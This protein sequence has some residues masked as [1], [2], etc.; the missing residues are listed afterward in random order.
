MCNYARSIAEIKYNASL[1]DE[2]VKNKTDIT[3]AWTYKTFTF[4]SERE[5][6]V[7]FRE[8]IMC[9]MQLGPIEAFNEKAHLK[10]SVTDL[11]LALYQLQMSVT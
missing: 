4:E 6:D 9:E 11:H 10:I 2:F 5:W 1:A 3:N 8:T 7:E